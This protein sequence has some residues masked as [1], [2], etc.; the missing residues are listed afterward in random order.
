MTAPDIT[1]ALAALH[2]CWADLAAANAHANQAADN[3]TNA[4]RTRA[5]ELASQIAD[6]LAFAKRLEFAITCD[7]RQAARDEKLAH[8]PW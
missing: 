7:L 4:R 1:A 5:G 2:D 3:L 6:C 8:G